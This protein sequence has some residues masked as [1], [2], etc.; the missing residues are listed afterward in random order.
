MCPILKT[1]VIAN[2]S[3]PHPSKSTQNSGKQSDNVN[4]FTGKCCRSTIQHRVNAN[5]LTSGQSD[6]IGKSIY[7]VAQQANGSTCIYTKLVRMLYPLK[8]NSKI[9]VRNCGIDNPIQ[10]NIIPPALTKDNP[11]VDIGSSAPPYLLTVCVM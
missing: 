8:V 6:V 10:D 1:T 5:A 3:A 7:K 11:R 2:S 9:S 4:N